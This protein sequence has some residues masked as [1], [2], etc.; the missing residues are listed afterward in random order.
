VSSPAPAGT[1]YG[2]G[3]WLD[4]RGP[5][6]EVLQISSPGAFGYTPWIDLERGVVGVVMVDYVNSLIQNDVWALQASSRAELPFLGAACYGVG[7]AL[8]GTRMRLLTNEIPAVGSPSFAFTG[9]GAPPGADGMLLVSAGSSVL[10]WPLLGVRIHVAPPV[11]VLLAVRADAAGRLVLP[12]P[13]PAG[14]RGAEVFTQVLWAATPT[15]GATGATGASS[16]L[17]VTVQ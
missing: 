11:P 3:C 14:T 13:I 9:E 4:R 12:A 1:R 6:G 8:C 15:C 2:I 7:T 5:N 10:G 17:A 16:G